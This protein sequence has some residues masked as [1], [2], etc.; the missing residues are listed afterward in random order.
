[1][2][3]EPEILYG[4]RYGVDLDEFVETLDPTAELRAEW[5]DEVSDKETLECILPCIVH[6]SDMMLG[7]PD[8]DKFIKKQIVD[9]PKQINMLRELSTTGLIR[10]VHSSTVAGTTS[11]FNKR[12]PAACIAAAQLSDILPQSMDPTLSTEELAELKLSPNELAELTR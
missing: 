5:D 11:D 4:Y 2:L 7:G 12:T 1:M 9:P 6:R 3:H 8:L 10:P